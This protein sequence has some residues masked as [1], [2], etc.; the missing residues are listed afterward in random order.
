MAAGKEQDELLTLKMYQTPPTALSAA[1]TLPSL[2]SSCVHLTLHLPSRCSGTSE[3]VSWQCSSSW[4]SLQSNRQSVIPFPL[5]KA[6]G[7]APPTNTHTQTLPQPPRSPFSSRTHCTF[8]SLTVTLRMDAPSVPAHQRG[9]REPSPAP[10]SSI[11]LPSVLPHCIGTAGPGP[12][13]SEPPGPAR[14]Q[15][16]KAGGGTAALGRAPPPHPHLSG[17]PRARPRD[18]MSHNLPP[19]SPVRSR[20]AVPAPGSHSPTAAARHGGGAGRQRRQFP[21]SRQQLP[22]LARGRAAHAHSAGA[23][24][25]RRAREGDLMPVPR[26]SRG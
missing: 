25:K 8:A 24:T 19:P 16:E 1:R 10:S 20:R 11:Q 7:A 26:P 18:P 2:T 5:G 17:T 23:R 3:S 22:P 6:E 9:L 12:D 14:G 21:I 15:R 13:S 4:S